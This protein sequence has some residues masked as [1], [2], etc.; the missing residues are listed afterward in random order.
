M[1][2]LL[3]RAFDSE[4]QAFGNN[5][6]TTA[7]GLD[8]AN[9]LSQFQPPDPSIGQYANAHLDQLFPLYDGTKR[10]FVVAWK[11]LQGK[12]DSKITPKLLTRLDRAVLDGQNFETLVDELLAA[13][14]PSQEQS[15]R[16]S[17]ASSKAR[18]SLVHNGNSITTMLEN[19]TR[20]N[21]VP[22]ISNYIRN[23]APDFPLVKALDNLRKRAVE[24][25]KAKLDNTSTLWARAVNLQEEK[26]TR[27]GLITD[28]QQ[29]HQEK[30]LSVTQ[31]LVADIN[32]ELRPSY[33]MCVCRP[34]QL[35]QA[36][37]D[38]GERCQIHTVAQEK[39]VGR[40]PGIVTYSE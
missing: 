9:Q 18:K 26:R 21:D 16:R 13:L 12:G 29:L 30:R 25:I 8:T 27:E 5:S 19:A 17:G 10:R 15:G 6:D 40:P 3:Q 35:S 20:L 24:L 2:H 4:I 31:K 32:Q 37:F 34:L 7:L 14:Q 39:V 33:P 11:I 28:I 22:F 38:D 23:T 36:V 1:N